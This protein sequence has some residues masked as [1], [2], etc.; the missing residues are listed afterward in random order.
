MSSNLLYRERIRRAKSLGSAGIALTVLALVLALAA[1]HL[2]DRWPIAFGLL[3]AGGICMG[4]ASMSNFVR[5]RLHSRILVS[6]GACLI[7]VARPSLPCST[8]P[9]FVN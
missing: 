8:A 5:S 1:P 7:V 4:V 2:A 6:L 3:L 9:H